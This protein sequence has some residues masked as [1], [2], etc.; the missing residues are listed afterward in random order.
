[1]GRAQAGIFVEGS[2]HSYF[3]E[4]DVADVGDARRGDG[5]YDRLTE[6]STPT[7]GAFYFAPSQEDLEAALA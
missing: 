5:I 4:Y 2:A 3:L 7:S 1:M 6:F